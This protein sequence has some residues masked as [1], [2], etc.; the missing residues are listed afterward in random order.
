M[1]EPFD[2][3]RTSICREV[4]ADLFAELKDTD[5]SPTPHEIEPLLLGRINVAL[6]I[7]GLKPSMPAL[8]PSVVAECLH[9]TFHVV[10]VSADLKGRRSSG[11]VAVY[12]AD[13]PNEGTYN[14][15]PVRL[16]ELVHQFSPDLS[17]RAAN[18]VIELVRERADV[19]LPCQDPN[20]VPVGNGVFSYSSKELV[21]FDPGLV[22]TSKVQVPLIFDAPEVRITQGDGTEWEAFEWSVDLF[23]GDAER[24]DLFWKSIGAAVRSGVPWEKVLLPFNE[25][26]ENGKG[27]YLVLVRGVLGPGRWA[28]IPMARFSK[29]FALARLV[30]IAA[31]TTDEN[32]VGLYLDQL[33]EFK[34]AVTGDPLTIEEKYEKAYDYVWR[35]FMIQCLNGFPKVKDTSSSIYRRL[36][37]FPFSKSFT[38]QANKA[39]KTDYLTR[40][41]VL[42]WALKY[43]LLDLPDYHDLPNP[44]AS[45]SVLGQ[46]QEHADLVR[47][48]WAEFSTQFVGPD[49]PTRMLY[50]LYKAWRLRYHASSPE[51]GDKEFERRLHTIV[52]DDW[53]PKEFRIRG[54]AGVAEPLLDEYQLLDWMEDKSI[55]PG[56]TVKT[57]YVKAGKFKGFRRMG[58]SHHIPPG[59]KGGSE[60]DD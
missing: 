28:S 39:I 17:T 7:A 48:F 31:V 46:F 50:A 12:E 54:L 5:A 58:P 49:Q 10:V 19:I 20:L 16:R 43:V 34:A 26:G 36:L 52:D 51:L 42:R 30:S 33:A 9:R 29:D 2:V 25:S 3:S 41:E 55:G 8:P 44:K 32:E 47:A 14:G 11:M 60:D 35:G 27:T 38:G 6:K 56:R 37:F 21:P 15:D 59:G 4:T 18:E 45:Q 13:G 57:P 40:P 23:D 53:E 24:V 1:A 22:F